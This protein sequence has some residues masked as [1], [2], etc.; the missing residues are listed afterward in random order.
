MVVCILVSSQPLAVLS[1]SGIL[2][3]LEVVRSNYDT[4]TL[5]LQDGL[6]QY[7]KYTE[8]PTETAFFTQL[9]SRSVCVSSAVQ[10]L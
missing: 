4:L 6:D 8:K 10:C 3:V 5:K 2:Q 9:V 7:D 1:Q